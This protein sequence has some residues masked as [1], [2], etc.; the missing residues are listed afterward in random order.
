[1][2]ELEPSESAY[3]VFGSEVPG[4]MTV[5][6]QN[7]EAIGNVALTV[8]IFQPTQVAAFFGIRPKREI[9]AGGVS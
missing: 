3:Q 4:G 9:I 2:S 6:C 5:K 8:I 7:C 1:M